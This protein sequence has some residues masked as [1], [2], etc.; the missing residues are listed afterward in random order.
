[1]RADELHFDA[2]PVPGQP[3]I[4]VDRAWFDHVMRH[5]TTRMFP[6]SVGESTANQEPECSLGRECDDTTHTHP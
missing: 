2:Q 5:G 6:E 4:V 1:M 3:T